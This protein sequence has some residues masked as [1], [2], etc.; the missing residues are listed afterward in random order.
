MLGTSVGLPAREGTPAV[1]KKTANNI[2]NATTIL[3]RWER[4]CLT[5]GAIGKDFMVIPLWE[6][7]A[8]AAI[9]GQFHLVGPYFS[10]TS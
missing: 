4:L 1:Q 2:Q 7:N 10:P 9:I 6:L 3:A 5:L 8:E